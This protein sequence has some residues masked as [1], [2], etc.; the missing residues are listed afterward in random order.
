[1]AYP[2]DDSNRGRGGIAAGNGRAQQRRGEEVEAIAFR[3]VERRPAA[4][5]SKSTTSA[6]IGGASRG[7]GIGGRAEHERVGAAAAGQMVG[8]AETFKGVIARA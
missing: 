2:L 1:M 7:R 6:T 8:S 5:R 3:T 4:L